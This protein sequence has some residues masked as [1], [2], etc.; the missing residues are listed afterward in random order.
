MLGIDYPL[1]ILIIAAVSLVY[2][3]TGGL[4]GVIWVDVIQMFVYLGGA[5]IASIYLLNILPDGWSSVLSSASE[6]SKF[7]IF[8]LGFSERII[9]F[10]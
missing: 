8:N 2:T 3:Y 7:E 1:A 4:K 9:R 5:I 6:S 10:F